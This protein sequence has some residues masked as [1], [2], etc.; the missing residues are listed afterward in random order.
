MPACSSQARIARTGQ[1][2]RPSLPFLVGLRSAESHEKSLRRGFQIRDA[3]RGQLRPAEAAGKTSQQQ[4]P[5]ARPPQ[6]L[7]QFRD[8][9]PEIGRE[10]RLLPALGDSFRSFDALPDFTHDGILHRR[11]RRL[12]S[13]LVRPVDGREAPRKAGCLER[14]RAVGQI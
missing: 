8:N 10:E 14:R 12:A 7:R 1:G 11:G 4:C 2:D 9:K 5:V 6:I 13:R 3:Q